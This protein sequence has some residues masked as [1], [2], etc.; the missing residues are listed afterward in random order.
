MDVD[1]IV[2]GMF[3]LILVFILVS[4]ASNFNSIVKSI[5]GVVTAQTQALQGVSTG[6]GGGNLI[7]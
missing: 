1:K 2:A 5:G 4:R 3:F 7:Q 6:F